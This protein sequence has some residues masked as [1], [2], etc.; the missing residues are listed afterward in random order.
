L[1]ENVKRKNKKIGEGASMNV[2]VLG[3]GRWGTFL[4]WNID[5]VGHDVLLWGRD[6]SRNPM[7]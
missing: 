4:A 3:C 2:S 1:W 7:D 5:K 6:Q